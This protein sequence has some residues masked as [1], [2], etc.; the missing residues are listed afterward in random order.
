MPRAELFERGITP[1]Q[2]PIKTH[3]GG[4]LY[5]GEDGKPEALIAKISQETLAE[6]VGT[7][8]S[9]VS[10]FTDKFRK[11]EFVA[12]NRG[13]RGIHRSLVNFLLCD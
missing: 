6:M 1:A 5:I 10:F 9:R 8:R 13:A 3:Q 7:T 12:Y 4:G 2:P 11:R